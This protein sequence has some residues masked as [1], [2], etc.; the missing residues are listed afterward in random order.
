MNI[1]SDGVVCDVLIISELLLESR[2]CQAI[3]I[4]YFILPSARVVKFKVAFF[5]Q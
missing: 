2:G 5:Q 1:A 4:I 3:T